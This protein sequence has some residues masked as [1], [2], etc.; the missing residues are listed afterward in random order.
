MDLKRDE[1]LDIV[2]QRA[3][4]GDD[5]LVMLTEC[6]D[7]MTLVGKRF[8]DGDYFLSELLLSGEIFKEATARLKP[9]I[10]A[11]GPPKTIGKVVLATMRGDVH[12]LGK[13][14]LATLLE[15]QGFEVHDLGVDVQPTSVV[16]KAKEVRPDFV[17]YSALITT[18]FPAMKE[19]TE[20][21]AAAGL[22]DDI[23][24]MVGGGVTT[25][26]VRTYAGADFHTLDASEGVAYCLQQMAQ[27]KGV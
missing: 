18:A 15:A 27:K 24:V 23:K 20:L 13:N 19:T 11:G 7:G 2:K 21:L 17:G 22:R 16:D 6:Q 25:E 14:I 9:Y 8:Q 10:A 5:P 1:A 26:D 12:D 4:A 3:E